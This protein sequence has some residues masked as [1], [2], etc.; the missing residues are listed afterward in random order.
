MATEALIVMDVQQAFDRAIRATRSRTTSP[1]PSATEEF[2]TVVTTAAIL[3]R[4]PR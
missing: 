2:A 4:A 3:E 1:A